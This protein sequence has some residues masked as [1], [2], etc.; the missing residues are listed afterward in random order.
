M[1]RNP[2]F[3]DFS[4]GGGEGPDSLPQ[5]PPPSGIRPWAVSLSWVCMKTHQFR[6]L[7]SRYKIGRLH[8][9]KNRDLL[10]LPRTLVGKDEHVHPTLLALR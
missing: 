10:F 1:L 6:S 5:P 2:I 3:G 7:R 8:R 4:G 9:H